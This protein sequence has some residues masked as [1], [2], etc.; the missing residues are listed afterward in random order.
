M[1]CPICAAE[2]ASPFGTKHGYSMQRCAQCD[3][4]YVDPMPG[5]AELDAFYQA[6]HKTGQYRAKLKSKTRRARNRIRRIRWRGRGRR[7]IDVGCNVGFAV[8]AARQLGFDAL[9]VD[10]D[11]AAIS[12]AR[13]LFPDARFRAADVTDLAAQGER[14][15]VVYCSEVIE[16]LAE[17]RPFVVALNRILAPNGRAFIT[18]P[19]IA[20]RSLPI[21]LIESDEIRP[22]EHLLYFNPRS[23][24]ILLA[25]AGFTS[26]RRQW[27]NKPTLKMVAR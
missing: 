23:L 6:Y 11:Q 14:F 16:H 7:F 22:P 13:E 4:L 9:G 5:G 25:E 1:T 20:H 26:I 27:T 18:T 17:P 12:E 8:E 3:S 15:D 2:E 24:E 19:N 10:V 21:E